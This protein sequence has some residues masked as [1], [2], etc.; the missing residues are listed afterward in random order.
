[1]FPWFQNNSPAQPPSPP[2]PLPVRQPAPI[3]DGRL[4]LFPEQGQLQS[5]YAGVAQPQ[6]RSPTLDY[7]KMAARPPAPESLRGVAARDLRQRAAFRSRELPIGALDRP[8][9]P[10]PVDVT[11]DTQARDAE[12]QLGGAL[13]PNEGSDSQGETRGSMQEAFP[14]DKPLLSNDGPVPPATADDILFTEGNKPRD[15]KEVNE[16]VAI[17]P[18]GAA[19]TLNKMFETLS[20]PAVSDEQLAEQQKSRRAMALL[21]SGLATMAA[22]SKPGATFLG[23]LGEGGLAGVGELQ[24]LQE[25]DKG[26]NA[27]A[28]KARDDK[29]KEMRDFAK[30][31]R[32]FGLKEAKHLE[33]VR[34]NTATETETAAYHKSTLAI[35]LKELQFKSKNGGKLKDQQSWLNLAQDMAKSDESSYAKA[36]DGSFKQFMNELGESKPVIDPAKYE[37][38]V[39][40]HGTNLNKEHKT[41]FIYGGPTVQK[42][43]A[44]GNAAPVPGSGNDDPLGIR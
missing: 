40:K 7:D 5:P 6:L 36:A 31:E 26:T 10:P 18:K 28:M 20:Q 13:P 12:G 3:P 43:A 22:A 42:P 30:D 27:A 39:R 23:S 11:R 32:D 8:M 14:I 1:M 37:A 41:S 44:G 33:K 38:N 16:A 35:R 29:V 15:E 24:R 4:M 19:S 9:M 21:V 34:S 2:S 25:R 17:N